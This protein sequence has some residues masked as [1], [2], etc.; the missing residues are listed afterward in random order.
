MEH[1]LYDHGDSPNQHDNS[2]KLCDGTF[3][4]ELDEKSV[5]TETT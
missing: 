2:H 4:H 3:R 1:L 5:E